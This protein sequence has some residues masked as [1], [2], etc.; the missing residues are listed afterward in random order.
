M[1]TEV[2][3]P[4]VG[5]S[6]TTGVVVAWLKHNGDQVQEGQDL[7]ELET[8]KAVLEIPS[9]GAGVLE[10]LVEEG[11]EVSI[12]QTVDPRRLPRPSPPKKQPSHLPSPRR[13][14]KHQLM[15]NVAL[16][17]YI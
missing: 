15:K 17:G 9:P 7:F 8:D 13:R 11:T 14:R 16:S 2:K 3:V 12:G 4:S 6:I 10:I 5:E 1:K